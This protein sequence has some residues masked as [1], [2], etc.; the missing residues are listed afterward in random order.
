MLHIE[1]VAYY[2]QESSKE[3]N[4]TKYDI[5]GSAIE[6]TSIEVDRGN[7]KQLQVSNRSSVIVRVWNMVRVMARINISRRTTRVGV[8][9]M[10]LSIIII[11]I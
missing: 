8:W 3:L 4:I 11:N 9:I 10:F 2:A 6:E 7:P 1:Q 5:Y